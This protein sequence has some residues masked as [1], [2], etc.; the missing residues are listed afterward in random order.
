MI[1][2]DFD[3]ELVKY[4]D[5]LLATTPRLGGGPYAKQHNTKMRQVLDTALGILEQRD[6]E[7]VGAL[8]MHIKRSWG[9]YGKEIS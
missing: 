9:G 5:T 3:E 1:E 8:R 6:D 4:T 7:R 2:I